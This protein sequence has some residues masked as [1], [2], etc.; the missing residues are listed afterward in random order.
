[1]NILF[2]AWGYDI[3]LIEFAASLLALI[4]VA[5]GVRGNRLVWPF[6]FVSGALYAVLFYEFT[7]FASALLQLIFIAAAIWGWFG[8]GAGGAVPRELRTRRRIEIAIGSVLLWI[9]LAPALKAIGGAA[10]WLDALVL[11]GSLVAQ[12]LMVLEYTESWAMWIAVN[13]VGTIH[14]ARQELF[15][16]ALLYLV[17]LLVAIA[18]WRTWRTGLK[19]NKT[20]EPAGL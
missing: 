2:T 13:V 12:V 5:L 3:T 7:Y 10:T 18:G 6:Y 14:Y 16:T 8:W 15:F 20:H 4:G 19:P 1:M 11:V 9:A 17:L